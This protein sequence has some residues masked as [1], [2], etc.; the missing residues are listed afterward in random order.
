[1]ERSRDLTVGDVIMRCWKAREM[2]VNTSS[3]C[4]CSHDH[5]KCD[6]TRVHG[7]SKCKKATLKRPPADTYGEDSEKLISS[8]LSS[9]RS[10]ENN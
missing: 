10:S 3:R 2:L 9:D 4:L 1:M 5:E 8:E 7:P 6:V